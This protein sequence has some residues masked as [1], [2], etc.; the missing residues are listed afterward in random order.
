MFSGLVLTA[1]SK[2][3]GPTSARQKPQVVLQ[4]SDSPGL[5]GASSRLRFHQYPKPS[6][7]RAQNPRLVC[8]VPAAM[9]QAGQQAVIEEVSDDEGISPDLSGQRAAPGTAA[10]RE[11]APVRRGR[12]ADQEGPTAMSDADN[13]SDSD[14][15]PGLAP[16]SDEVGWG[17][18]EVGLGLPRGALWPLPPAACAAASTQRVDSRRTSCVSSPEAPTARQAVAL[19]AAAATPWG[20]C[21][22]RALPNM[23]QLPLVSG[24]GGGCGMGQ[25][26][27]PAGFSAGACCLGS[28]WEPTAPLG[29]PPLP[30]LATL[31]KGGHLCTGHAALLQD[32]DLPE[33]QS[34]VEG[35]D[36][37]GMGRWCMGAG[38]G[39]S[40]GRGWGV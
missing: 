35:S 30:A 2:E 25:G 7:G 23:T 4:G 36:E 22:P 18:A 19:A 8:P 13:G 15:A 29:F 6:A 5:P 1:G 32:D 39:C 24:V 12:S 20:P 34:E 14:S 9:A 40:W 38:K 10:R 28:T 16:A 27:G 17:G 11:G 21:M 26:R 3:Q 31:P 37:G 33:L